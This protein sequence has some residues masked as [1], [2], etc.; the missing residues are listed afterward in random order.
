MFT[1]TPNKDFFAQLLPELRQL[2]YR[3]RDLDLSDVMRLTWTCRAFYDEIGPWIRQYTAR[4]FVECPPRPSE[5][6]ADTTP[7]PGV[8]EFRRHMKRCL[9]HEWYTAGLFDR[10]ETQKLLDIQRQNFGPVGLY[11]MTNGPLCY[12]VRDDVMTLGKPLPPA[13]PGTVNLLEQRR[14]FVA[15]PWLQVYHGGH[16]YAHELFDEDEG[17]RFLMLR[18]HPDHWP[19]RRFFMYLLTTTN[20][21]ETPDGTIYTEPGVYAQFNTLEHMYRAAPT[22]FKLSWVINDP[23]PLSTTIPTGGF[24]ST[25]F[26]RLRASAPAEGP[27][28][29]LPR[30][31]D[32][33]GPLLPTVYEHEIHAFDLT[34]APDPV[35]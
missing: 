13:A 8:L 24:Q 1:F 6:P 23:P 29:E 16:E 4:D 21:Y 14:R 18:M 10:K 17:A 31:R 7:Y 2:M 15:M 20:T 34:R 25:T 22:Y 12:F 26:E 3:C 9:V 35:T 19:A 28:V 11:L 30:I 5:C 33:A 32:R 27:R